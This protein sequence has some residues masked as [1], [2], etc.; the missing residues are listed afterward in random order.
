[1]TISRRQFLSVASA[2]FTGTMLSAPL[3][4]LLSSAAQGLPTHTHHYGPLIRDPQGML[5]LPRGFQYRILS[6]EG[7]KMSDGFPVPAK[8]DGMAAFAGPQR[9]TIL[10]RNHELGSDQSP[11]VQGVNPYDPKSKGG[12]TTLVIDRDRKL[13]RD[14]ASLTGTTRNCG[15]GATPWGSWISCEENTDTP[16]SEPAV[17]KRHGYAFEVPSQATGPIQ[18]QPLIAMGRFYRE[19]VAVDP[20]TGIVYQT[21]DR[22]DGLFYRFIPHRPGQLQAGGLLEALKIKGKPQAITKKGFPVGKSW[23][24]E[25]V[26]IDNPDPDT[27]SIRQEGFAKGAAQ[28]MRGEGSLFGAKRRIASFAAPSGG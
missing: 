22:E 6:R 9:T 26:P 18:P 2:S 27:D 8:H 25:W 28:F 16:E 20:K 17:S 1:M 19:A 24:V 4:H 11:A 12:T 21:E 13:L 23:P 7:Q 10:V 5:D 14:Y 15:G 3:S